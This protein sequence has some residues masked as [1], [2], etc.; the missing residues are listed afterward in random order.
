MDISR[1][2]D[3]HFQHPTDAPQ[4]ARAGGALLLSLFLHALVIGSLVWITHGRPHPE[5][6]HALQIA[7]VPAPSTSTAVT[8]ALPEEAGLQIPPPPVESPA[9][10]TATADTAPDAPVTPP[11]LPPTVGRTTPVMNPSGFDTSFLDYVRRNYLFNLNRWWQ[12]RPPEYP[13]ELRRAGIQGRAAV[14]IIIDRQGNITDV[15]ISE[16]SGNAKLDAAAITA[17]RA[18][19]PLPQPPP[20]LPY[21]SQ[22][23]ELSVDWQIAP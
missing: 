8:D 23:M 14:L 12:N 2:P 22:E 17:V 20:T 19:S 5:G 15:S 11:P 16:S 6:I 9:P 10:A 4:R 21:E 18:R 7:L 3:E 13:E 1:Q